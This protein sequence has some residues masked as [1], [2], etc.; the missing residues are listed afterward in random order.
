M[1]LRPAA[2]L[3]L[4]AAFPACSRAR[5]S[6]V[7]P[8]AATPLGLLSASCRHQGAAPHDVELRRH[9]VPDAAGSRRD[10][11]TLVVQ[12]LDLRSGAVLQGRVRLQV[13]GTERAPAPAAATSG[14]WTFTDV[15]PGDHRLSVTAIGYTGV[16][17]L[18]RSDAGVVDT[19]VTRLNGQAA[20]YGDL[21]CDR[22][23][24]AAPGRR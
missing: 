17:G 24:P 22:P 16:D 1:D 5:S 3:L 13:G 8:A 11:G 6:R 14:W 9:A 7:P 12:V 15:P 2:C 21:G 4:L 18:V 20:V 19:L 10:A 23:G